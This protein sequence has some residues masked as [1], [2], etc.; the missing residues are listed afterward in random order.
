MLHSA[1]RGRGAKVP[2]PPACPPAGED[3]ILRRDHSAGT[4]DPAAEA[5][6]HYDP[7]GALARIAVTL[8][9]RPP[10]LQEGCSP[11]DPAPDLWRRGR[12]AS[13]ALVVRPGPSELE[14]LLIKRATVEGDPWSGHMALP[15]GRR[16]PTDGSSLD[17]AIREAREEVGLDLAARGRLLGQLDDVEPRAGAPTIVV[18]AY[19]F[20]VGADAAVDMNHEVAL[21]MWVPL[22]HLRDPR[23][24]TEHLHAMAS[25]AA[26]RFPAIGYQNHVIWGITHRIIGHFLDMTGILPDQ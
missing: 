2:H 20:S 1:T 3:A 18:S 21:A 8:A 10:R 23:S 9:A 14:L 26:L 13:V 25:G 15:G 22:G 17:T 4:P 5:A 6:V 12:C 7:E 16:G 24:A 19:A 11:T